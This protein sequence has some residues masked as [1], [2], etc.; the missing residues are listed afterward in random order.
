[1]RFIQAAFDEM[2]L[3]LAASSGA[4]DADVIAGVSS[5]VLTLAD[6]V[7]SSGGASPLSVLIRDSANQRIL[8]RIFTVGK[9]RFIA[10][11]VAQ[12][13]EIS[14]DAIDPALA[15][16]EEILAAQAA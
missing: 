15:A 10:T 16:L 3:P 9:S 4:R 7:T 5:L 14:T 2:G 1:M 6:R 12:G 11:A 8:H 13:S